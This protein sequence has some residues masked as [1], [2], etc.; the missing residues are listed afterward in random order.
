MHEG[1]N[2]EW[3]AGMKWREEVEIQCRQK[4]TSARFETF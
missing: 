4:A 1:R 2:R 3:I